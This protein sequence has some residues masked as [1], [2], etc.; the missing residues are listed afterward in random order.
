MAYL[1]R[2]KYKKVQDPLKKFVGV[3][4][5]LRTHSCLSLYSMVNNMSKSAVMEEAF[6]HWKN[7]YFTPEVEE[8]SYLQFS[9]MMYSKFLALQL[10]RRSLSYP[11]FINEMKKE[12]EYKGLII[13]E[14]KRIL[15]GIDKEHILIKK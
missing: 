5:P 15:E 7:S 9:K 10:T 11:I 14:I 4:I 13:P 8:A 1:I 12:L 6:L 3:Y 2:T